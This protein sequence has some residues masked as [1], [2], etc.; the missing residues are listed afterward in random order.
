VTGRL[1]TSRSSCEERSRTR[2]F[3]I[4]EGGENVIVDTHERSCR[5]PTLKRSALKGCQLRSE[6]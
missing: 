5:K 1:L 3:D 4:G 6:G 2:I